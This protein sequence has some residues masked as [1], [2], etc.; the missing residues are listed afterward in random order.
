MFNVMNTFIHIFIFITI[1][2]GMNTEGK[3]SIQYQYLPEE[4]MQIKEYFLNIA[5]IWLGPDHQP[6]K[7]MTGIRPGHGHIP[8]SWALLEHVIWPSRAPFDA[9]DLIFPGPPPPRACGGPG[10]HDFVT[11][12]TPSPRPCTCLSLA[13]VYILSRSKEQDNLI[14]LT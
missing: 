11:P 12:V 6:A 9:H 8:F 1:C 13:F 10:P 2:T 4:T 14:Q 3:N 7:A 5:K